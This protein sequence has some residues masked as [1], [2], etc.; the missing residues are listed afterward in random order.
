M[1]DTITHRTGD[2]VFME[3]ACIVWDAVIDPSVE[4]IF[5]A[6]AT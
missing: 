4:D 1:K 2:S 3:Y 5:V 6:G